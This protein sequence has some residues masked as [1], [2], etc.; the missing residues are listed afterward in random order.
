MKPS[1]GKVGIAPF[2][3]HGGRLAQAHARYPHATRPWI[4]LSTGI[5]PWAYPIPDL[6]VE[7]WTRLPEP[8]ALAGLIAAARAYYRV[9][10]G[11]RVVPVPGTDVAIGMIPRLVAGKRRVAIVS[12]TYASHASAWRAAG[13]EVIEVTTP[14]QMA[15][16]DIG[17]VVNPNNPDGSAWDAKVLTAAAGRL[18]SRGGCL[19]VDE[20]FGDTAPQLSVL[21]GV[22]DRPGL[23]V[24]RSFGKFFGLAGLRLG[25]VI[26]LHPIVEMVE[27]TLGAWPVS[28]AAAAI[29]TRALADVAWHDAQLRRLT[30]TSRALEATLA[31]HA[32]P[33]QGVTTLFRFVTHHDGAALFEHLAVNGILVRPFEGGRR[34]RIGLP[35]GEEQ[36]ERLRLALAAFNAGRSAP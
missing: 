6:P 26:G 12:P 17:V 32:I 36:M 18:H 4:D 9:S 11:M 14:D 8:E 27:Q 24:L 10:P 2:A 29:G 30:D 3:V 33:C 13:H 19:I 22:N 7:C 5:A 20:A 1:E 21:D 25:F 16:G 35:G 28:A 31:S 23:V 34:L 15:P